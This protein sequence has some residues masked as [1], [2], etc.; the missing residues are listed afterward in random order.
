MY[1][2]APQV[3]VP[4]DEMSAARAGFSLFNQITIS[5]SSTTFRDGEDTFSLSLIE[6]SQ[7]AD[8]VGMSLSW[9]DHA[10]EVFV[11]DMSFTKFVGRAGY[12]PKTKGWSQKTKEMVLLQI[13]ETVRA[14]FGSLVDAAISVQPKHVDPKETSDFLSANFLL[15]SDCLD[16]A[17]AKVLIAGPKATM[18]HLAQIWEDKITETQSGFLANKEATLTVWSSVLEL[19]E[20]EFSQLSDGDVLLLDPECNLFDAPDI[21]IDGR[22]W[23]AALRD[24]EDIYM[25]ASDLVAGKAK[26]DIR[27]GYV[28]LRL[29]LETT[30][31]PALFAVEMSENTPLEILKTSPSWV[32]I[33]VGEKLLSNAKIIDVDDALCIRLMSKA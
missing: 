26:P 4:H 9:G 3:E 30:N 10:I 23:G 6:T 18:R 15:E 28:A 5:E 33:F 31:I 20:G 32:R 22:K 19:E 1:D 21:C 25:L 13:S 11:D 12:D 24:G 7:E 16:K 8:W 27:A 2:D 14:T 17:P 29:E